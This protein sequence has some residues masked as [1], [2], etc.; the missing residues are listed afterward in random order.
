[1]QDETIPELEELLSRDARRMRPSPI[2]EIAKIV[3]NPKIINL[4]GGQP[5]AESFPL[6]EIKGVLAELVDKLPPDVLRYGLTAGDSDLRDEAIRMMAERQVEAEADEVILTNGS[7]RALD[8]IGRVLL[9]PGDV[10]LTELPTYSGAIACFRNLRARLEGVEMD[11]D[12]LRIDRLVRR[13]ERLKAEGARIKL[14]YTIPTFQNPSGATLSAER[15]KEIAEIA[16]RENFI[17]L[18][19]DP[20]SALYFGDE[21]PPKPLAA[22]SRRTVYLASFSK[23]LAPG[24]R[25]AFVRG[26]KELIRKIEV[27]AQASDLSAGTLDQRLILELCRGGVLRRS[28]EKARVF[29]R[30]QRDHLLKAMNEFMPKGITWA[31]PKGGFFTWVTLTGDINSEGLLPKAVEQGVA[32]VPGPHFCVDGSMAGA[33]RLCF[34]E[35]PPQRLKQG[36]AALTTAIR[37]WDLPSTIPWALGNTC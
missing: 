10:V 37:F 32:Y 36:V 20:Y 5:S 17:V 14:L 12:G 21:Q 18:E 30:E 27:A 34:S 9:D 11:G 28:I 7:Q 24:L 6:E 23:V 16:E 26:P 31:E 2:R 1:M 29:Y 8:L 33:L 15:R 22:I 4:A 35:E 25:T 19:D 3:R 13:I